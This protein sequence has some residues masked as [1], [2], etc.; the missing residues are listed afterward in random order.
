VHS[1][2]AIY[3]KNEVFKDEELN[4]DNRKEGSNSM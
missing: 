4:S 1:L 3:N 2:S